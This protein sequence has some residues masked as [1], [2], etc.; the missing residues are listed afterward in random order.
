VLALPPIVSRTD[1][2]DAVGL[3]LGVT[4]HAP[5]GK[6]AD[7]ISNALNLPP[8]LGLRDRSGVAERWGSSKQ[9]ASAA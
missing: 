3:G 9:I 4:E 6:A 1:R 7:E 2:V 8:R 5:D